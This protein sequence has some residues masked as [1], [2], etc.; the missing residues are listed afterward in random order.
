MGE[1]RGFERRSVCGCGWVGVV[2]V[3]GDG[4]G[5]GGGW[6][7]TISVQRES[8][9]YRQ[10]TT[11]YMHNFTLPWYWATALISP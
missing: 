7:M 2:V 6:R 1:I 8:R 9:D 10:L 11:T 5:G 3:G 4:G